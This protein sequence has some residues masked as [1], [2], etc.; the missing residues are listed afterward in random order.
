MIKIENLGKNN[1]DVSSCNCCDAKN[2]V[3]RFDTENQNPAEDI[4]EI[5]FNDE[6]NK[7]ALTIRLCKRH[8]IELS[9]EIDFCFKLF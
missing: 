1:S 4:Y 7:H 9:N 2:Y 3:S 5:E 6:R 8:I